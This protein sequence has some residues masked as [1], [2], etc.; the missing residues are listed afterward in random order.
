M[1]AALLG[2]GADIDNAWRNK[3]ANAMT[4][5]HKLKGKNARRFNKDTAQLTHA[6][7][8]AGGMKSGESH[9]EIALRLKIS[10]LSVKRL[11]APSKTKG[12]GKE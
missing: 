4:G 9:Q 10:R 5:E 2:S 3:L 7:N 6:A 12:S 11:L 1:V 8:I